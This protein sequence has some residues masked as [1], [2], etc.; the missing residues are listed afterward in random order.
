MA[1]FGIDGD[2]IEITGHGILGNGLTVK[3]NGVELKSCTRICLD[4]AA[5]SM[6]RLQLDI[7]ATQIEID[8]EA[9]SELVA[10]VDMRKKA[11][12]DS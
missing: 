4:L 2:R 8:A 9:L 5:D 11:Q 10:F 7:S 6:N 3:L 12:N 1:G